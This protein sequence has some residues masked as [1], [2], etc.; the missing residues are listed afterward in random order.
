MTVEQENLKNLV[1]YWIHANPNPA[2][3]HL[4]LK[5][6]IEEL[7]TGDILLSELVSFYMTSFTYYLKPRI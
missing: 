4:H 6:G 3:D 7:S 5:V 2:S 1:N